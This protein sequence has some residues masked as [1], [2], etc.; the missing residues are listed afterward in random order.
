MFSKQFLGLILN[1][2]VQIIL[3]HLFLYFTFSEPHANDYKHYS[4]LGICEESEC[5]SNFSSICFSYSDDEF[6]CNLTTIDLNDR[7]DNFD[8]CKG[9]GCIAIHYHC[10]LLEDTNKYQCIDDLPDDD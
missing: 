8:Q 7:W 2:R 3:L 9:N 10:Y 1:S 4:T 6:V 5:F